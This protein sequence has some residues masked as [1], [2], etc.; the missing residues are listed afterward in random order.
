MA[1]INLIYGVGDVLHTH[2]NINPFD[3]NADGKMII[4]DSVT[5]ID[6]YADNAELLE[7]IATDVIDYF[8]AQETE[9]IISGWISKIRLGGKIV[10]GGIDLMEVCKAFS[11]YSIDNNFANVLL[12]GQQNP[13]YMIKKSTSMALIVASFLQSNGFKVIKKRI[14]NYQ[15]IVEAKRER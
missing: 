1:K 6:K 13:Q 10:V 5:N 7:L 12:H 9:K 15:M 3:N 8:P 14:E 2:T 4:R 11:S